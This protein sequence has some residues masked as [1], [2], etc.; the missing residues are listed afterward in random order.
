MEL[1]EPKPLHFA[2]NSQQLKLKLIMKCQL[3]NGLAEMQMQ[4]DLLNI[5]RVNLQKAFRA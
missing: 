5:L 2:C 4:I 3:L 1:L